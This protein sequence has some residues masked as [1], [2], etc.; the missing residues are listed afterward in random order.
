MM[1]QFVFA[2]NASSMHT[3]GMCVLIGSTQVTQAFG[4]KPKCHP[5]NA[6]HAKACFCPLIEDYAFYKP[7]FA[8]EESNQVMPWGT[9]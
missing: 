5:S 7:F 1:Y 4:Q 6:F 3:P 9:K 2:M 8:R